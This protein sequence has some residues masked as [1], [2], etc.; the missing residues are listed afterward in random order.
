MKGF[1]LGFNSHVAAVFIAESGDIREPDAMILR[2]RLLAAQRDDFIIHLVKNVYEQSGL[3]GK[4]LDYHVP[5]L[6]DFHMLG[7]FNRI[8]QHISEYDT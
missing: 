5:V 7:S 8:I 2:V 3:M 1:L 4:Y 6:C